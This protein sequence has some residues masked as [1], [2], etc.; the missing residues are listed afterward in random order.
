M[1]KLINLLKDEEGATMAE[2]TLFFGIL[3]VI[4]LTIVYFCLTATANEIKGA[5]PYLV[6]LGIAIVLSEPC[7]GLLRSLF[8]KD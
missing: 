6:V 5:I 2:Y 1:K 4:L 7:K 3:L 8:N